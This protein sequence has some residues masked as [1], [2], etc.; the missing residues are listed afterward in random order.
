MNT[1][2]MLAEL[3]AL[4]A[5]AQSEDGKEEGPTTLDLSKKWGIARP[6]VQHLLFSWAQNG[7]VKGKRTRRVSPL[8]GMHYSTFVY[9]L[10]DEGRKRV[11]ELT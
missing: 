7:W 1:E 5:S 3:D 9:F 4:K 2:E 8:T 11:K 6:S 10:T